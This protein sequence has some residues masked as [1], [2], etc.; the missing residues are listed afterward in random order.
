MSFFHDAKVLTLL[1]VKPERGDYFS[2][3]YGKNPKQGRNTRSI[4]TQYLTV[5][6]KWTTVIPSPPRSTGAEWND[7]TSGSDCRCWRIRVFRMP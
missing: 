5:H 2:R 1:Q 7:C 4:N 6:F 3:F